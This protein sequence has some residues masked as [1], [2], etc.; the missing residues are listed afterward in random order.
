MKKPE[1]LEKFKL[2][3]VRENLS[4]KTIS[5]YAHMVGAYIDFCNTRKFKTRSE[6]VNGF[7]TMLLFGRRPPRTVN[8][9]IAALLKYFTVVRNA[10]TKI[11]RIPYVK[12]GRYLPKTLTVQEVQRIFLVKMNPKH[13]LLLALTY[14]CGLRVS[15][16]IAIRNRDIF[17]DSNMIH[18]TG[19]GSKERLV[20]IHDI[21]RGLLTAHMNGGEYLFPGQLT[22]H[23]TVRTAEKI[24]TNALITAS[25]GRRMGIHALRHSYATHML[26]D[27]NNMRVIQE[28]LGHSSIRTTEIY[29]HVSK[30][31]LTKIRSPISNIA[32]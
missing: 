24:F 1:A 2:A 27:G 32:I 17:L 21:P 16:V 30:A 19:K 26:E 3:M 18:V 14:G 12:E 29:T 6:Y 9:Y 8:L 28:V 10:N 23:T 5:N 25:I 31:H 13:K 11:D 7:V 4:P 20:P 22:G 15:E